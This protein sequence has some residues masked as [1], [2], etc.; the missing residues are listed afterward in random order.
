MEATYGALPLV[1]RVVDAL[2]IETFSR[3]LGPSGLSLG[4]DLLPEVIQRGGFAGE[5][6]SQADDGDVFHRG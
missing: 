6:A 1:V 4:E 5:A 2:D 3:E